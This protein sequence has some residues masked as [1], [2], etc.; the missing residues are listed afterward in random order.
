MKTPSMLSRWQ[1]AALL[2]CFALVLPPAASAERIV[3]A[4]PS[5]STSFLPLVV[6]H[7]RG[8]FE[9]EN[10]QP[11]LVQVRPALAIPGLTCHA[12]PGACRCFLLHRLLATGH[13]RP[14]ASV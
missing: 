3:F 13:W 8:F 14:A 11:E 6:A 2:F 5:P 12:K 10:L 1:F 4:Y 9:Q 7:K